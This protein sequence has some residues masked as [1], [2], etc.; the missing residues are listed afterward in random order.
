VNWERGGPENPPLCPVP[1]GGG[2]AMNF[3]LYHYEAEVFTGTRDECLQYVYDN[4]S[5]VSSFEE[6]EVFE[7]YSMTPVAEKG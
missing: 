5:W 4:C 7:G 2:N 1:N 3:V 6:A